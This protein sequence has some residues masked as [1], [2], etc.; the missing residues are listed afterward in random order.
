MDSQFY[1]PRNKKENNFSYNIPEAKW[2]T[3]NI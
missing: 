2:S 1:L 3:L